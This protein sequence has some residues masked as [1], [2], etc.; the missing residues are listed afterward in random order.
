M[1]EPIAFVVKRNHRG[2]ALVARQQVRRV[3]AGIAFFLTRVEVMP[4]D[5]TDEGRMRAEALLVARMA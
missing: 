5:G 3:V 2:V 4:F 1:S